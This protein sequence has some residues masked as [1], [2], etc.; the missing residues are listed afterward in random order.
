MS[1][2]SRWMWAYALGF[3]VLMAVYAVGISRMGCIEFTGSDVTIGCSN[4]L[5]GIDWFGLATWG[6]YAG[7][8]MVLGSALVWALRRRPTVTSFIVWGT[9]G[10][11]WAGLHAWSYVPRPPEPIIFAILIGMGLLGLIGGV[12]MARQASSTQDS[13]KRQRLGRNAV[14]FRSA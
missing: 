8:T 11:H 13:P 5:V 14:G 3:T 9:V 10:L 12:S 7:I 2:W 4:N 1:K 6:F